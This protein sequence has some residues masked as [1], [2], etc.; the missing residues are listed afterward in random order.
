MYSIE[1]TLN[2]LNL[3]KVV[4]NQISN[5]E[6]KSL[7]TKHNLWRQMHDVFMINGNRLEQN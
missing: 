4:F 5:I 2:P 7:R 3:E 1:K 6:S